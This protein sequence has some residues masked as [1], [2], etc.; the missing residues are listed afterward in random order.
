MYVT[1]ERCEDHENKLGELKDK[2]DNL[3]GSLELPMPADFHVKM[4][5]EQLKDI[6]QEIR[7]IY[8]EIVGH[9]PWNE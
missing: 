1:N 5:K 3:L 4:M 7:D 8:I 2:V 9:D 6:S